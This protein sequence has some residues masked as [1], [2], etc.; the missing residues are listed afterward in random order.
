ML[1][2][3]YNSVGS[4]LNHCINPLCHLYFGPQRGELI[5]VQ[6]QSAG[7]LPKD[8][9]IECKV[10]SCKRHRKDLLKNEHPIY[11]A[12]C[13]ECGDPLIASNS[14]ITAE[15]ACKGHMLKQDSSHRSYVR[16]VPFRLGYL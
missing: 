11:V 1:S 15:D 10:D 6:G 13:Q 2:A 12:M 8:N 9:D 5:T 4:F 14:P 7:E 3:Q 16:G